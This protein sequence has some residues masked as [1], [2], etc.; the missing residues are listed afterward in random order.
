MVAADSAALRKASSA[1]RKKLRKKL[2]KARAQAAAIG[3][4]VR[5]RALSAG[6]SLVVKRVNECLRRQNDEGMSK[7]NGH[8]DSNSAPSGG[9][10]GSR[11]A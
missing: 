4:L 9:E 6:V 10:E 3:C 5:L 11:H 8:A 1:K 2:R 7:L